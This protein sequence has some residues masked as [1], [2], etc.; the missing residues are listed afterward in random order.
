MQNSLKSAKIYLP[1]S[2]LEKVKR[3][4]EKYTLRV[5]LWDDLPILLFAFVWG[6]SYSLLQAVSIL[7]LL[8]SFW[9]VYEIGYCENDLIA[10]KYEEQP[11][12]SPTYHKYKGMMTTFYPWFWSF[13]S[14]SIGIIILEKTQGVQYLFNESW[15]ETKIASI[16]PVLLMA[17]YWTAFLLSMRVCFWVYNNL[18]KYTRTWLYIFLQSFRYYGFLTVTS[19]NPIGA[20]LLSSNIICRSILYVVYRYSGGGS[21]DWPTQLPE[22]ILRCLIFIFILGTISLSGHS[23]QLWNNWQ[24]WAII[25][26]CVI[27][28]K[29]QFIKMFFRVK[30]IFEDGSNYIK[31]TFSSGN[32]YHQPK[33]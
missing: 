21:N 7:F 32:N 10:E 2:Y 6:A 30:P 9:C 22:K 4:N 19:I 5:I 24:T 8:I 27:Q 28:G 26:W 29:G 20:S 11:K 3:V 17:F 1:F 25:A 33:I 18:N 16:S 23:L 31:P 12:L 14:G 13:L 15:I